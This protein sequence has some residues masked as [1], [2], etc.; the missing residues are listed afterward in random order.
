MARSR[1]QDAKADMFCTS[2][3]HGMIDVCPDSEIIEW[4]IS[5]HVP[6]AAS[7]RVT[8]TPLGWLAMGGGYAHTN[9]YLPFWP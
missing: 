5:R 1:V 7:E 4:C 8:S 2:L 6:G 9:T 3:H